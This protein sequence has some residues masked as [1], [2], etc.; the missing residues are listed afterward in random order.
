MQQ[1]ICRDD[2]ILFGKSILLDGNPK[3]VICLTNASDKIRNN[4]FHT[5]M[6]V[7]NNKG[8][9]FDLRD[10]MVDSWDNLSND[11]IFL[12]IGHIIQNS[13][14]IVSHSE[15]GEYGHIQ[16]IRCHGIAKYIA[17][18]LNLPFIT[19]DQCNKLPESKQLI[20]NIVLGIY[21]SQRKSIEKYKDWY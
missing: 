5:C 12:M 13:S 10:S 20:K 8:H 3:I 11:D 17:D 4:E 15:N 14:R 9:M 21:K 19:F 1:I 6:A 7:T 18:K 16:H 2:E